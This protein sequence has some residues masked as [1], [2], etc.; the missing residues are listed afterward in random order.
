MRLSELR[1]CDKCGGLIAPL[2]TVV[3]VSQA[4]I[5]ERAARGVLGLTTMFNG[6]LGLAEAMAPEPEA[7]MVFG[8]KDG[9]LMTEILLCQECALMSPVSLGSLVERR[10]QDELPSALAEIASAQRA[11]DAE[12][13]P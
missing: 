11:S 12:L 5:N 2:F 1:P 9:R 4:M 7:V 6:A 3:R 10:G 8:D 13:A